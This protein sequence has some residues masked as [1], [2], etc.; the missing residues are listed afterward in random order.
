MYERKICVGNFHPHRKFAHG[1]Q[2][3]K[4]K[5]AGQLF[6]DKI[7]VYDYFQITLSGNTETFL[8]VNLKQMKS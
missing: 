3:N 7:K 1:D 4:M 8:K 2:Q 6:L 5:K